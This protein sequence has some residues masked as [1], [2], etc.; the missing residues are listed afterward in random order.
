MEL[1]A[2]FVSLHVLDILLFYKWTIDK[3]TRILSL[4]RTLVALLRLFFFLVFCYASWMGGVIQGVWKGTFPKNNKIRCSVSRPHVHSLLLL[5]AAAVSAEK[6]RSWGPRFFPC[7]VIC[8]TREWSHLSLL[9]WRFSGGSFQMSRLMNEASGGAGGKIPSAESCHNSM[10]YWDYSVEIECLKGPQ[11]YFISCHV[12]DACNQIII[13]VFLF[14]WRC[15]SGGG[16]WKDLAGTEQ[17]LGVDHPPTA[18]TH[19]RSD[20]RNA[21]NDSN[22]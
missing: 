11:G 19:R 12:S 1:L 20:P 18:G 3:S 14:L 22:P 21:G 13:R 17:G 2:S 16:T 9:S 8:I 10:E 7:L 15:G 6:K 5:A 4:S